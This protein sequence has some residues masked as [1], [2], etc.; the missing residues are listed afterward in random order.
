VNGKSYTAAFTVKMDPRVTISAAGLQKKFRLE[1]RLASLL[2]QTSVALAQA[3]SLSE[4]LKKLSLPSN[5]PVRDS[6]QAF[7]SKLTD[8]LGPAAG[9]PPS[10]AVNLARVNG[11]IAALYGAIWQ[12][13][14]E[15]TIAQSE[16]SDTSAHDTVDVIRR[17]ELLKTSDLPVL[18]QVLHG[19][20]LPEVHLELNPHQE[21]A[22]MDE[23]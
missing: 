21:D 5:G 4:A 20:H 12:A 15:P 9:S 3:N 11:D 14:A 6:I 16:A 2:T 18:N 8:V 23:E 17:W 22:G 19:A 1:S 10:E 13:D 7:Q